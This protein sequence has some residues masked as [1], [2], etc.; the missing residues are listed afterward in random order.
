MTFGNENPRACVV[1]AGL[2]GSMLATYLAQRGII[3]DL[4]EK[5]PDARNSF[6][7][8][9]RTIDMSISTR[10]LRGLEGIDLADAALKHTYPK[11]SHRHRLNITW[12]AVAA[13]ITDGIPPDEIR[14]RFD[15]YHPGHLF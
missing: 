10:G 6:A 5:R 14:R 2:V 3:V 11:H 4:Y 8:G 15:I 1:G 13:K 7:V 9:N 12:K